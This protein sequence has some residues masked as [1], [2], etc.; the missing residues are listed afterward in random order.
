MK[1]SIALVLAAVLLFSAVSV[2][3]GCRQNTGP[4]QLN[5]T[6]VLPMVPNEIWVVAKDG[7]ED[8]CKQLGVTPV[9]VMPSMPND[10]NQMNN[11]METAIIQKTNG[12]LTQAVNPE[13][14]S[15]A[16]QKLNDAKIPFTLVSSDAPGSGRIAKVGTGGE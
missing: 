15:P 10:I 7:F 2:F 4:K 14:M 6:F 8:A 3:V 1:R 12:L 9:V 13:G 11:L 5:Y 16:F